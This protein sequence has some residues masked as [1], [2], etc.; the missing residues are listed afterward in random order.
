MSARGETIEKAW[1]EAELMEL[2]EDGYT[3][4]IVN[5]EMVISPKNNWYHGRIC[6]RLLAA[7]LNFVAEHRLGAVLDSSTE[8]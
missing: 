6:S 2:P 1:T 5:G 3:H 7:L 8:T 4:E